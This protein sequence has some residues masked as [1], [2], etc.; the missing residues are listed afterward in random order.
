MYRPENNIF[1]LLK[2]WYFSPAD[3][4]KVLTPHKPFCHKLDSFCCIL[5]SPVKL[6]FPLNISFLLLFLFSSPFLHYFFPYYRL[7]PTGGKKERGVWRWTY[8]PGPTI[9]YQF[10][11]PYTNGVTQ[12]IT[13]CIDLFHQSVELFCHIGEI[14]IQHMIRYICRKGE[15][16]SP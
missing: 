10:D 13:T 5:F 16:S 2:K 7:I 12:S 4:P 1:L 14:D 8:V 3:T 15:M 11:E 9:I 6:L